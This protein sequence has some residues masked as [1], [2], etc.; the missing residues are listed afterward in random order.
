MTTIKKEIMQSILWEELDDSE[1]LQYNIISTGRW[2]INHELIFKYQGK[3]Y[4]TNYSVGATEHHYE[5]PWTYVVEDITVV[6]VKPVEK[7]IIVYVPI[8]D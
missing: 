7:T 2:S 6:E 1:I 3:I 8:T 5:Q 4:K